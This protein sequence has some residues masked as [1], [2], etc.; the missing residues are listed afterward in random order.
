[1]G[2]PRTARYYE[3]LALSRMTGEQIEAELTDDERIEYERL[4][5]GYEREKRK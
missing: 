5:Y 3:M 1:M 4:S 2:R